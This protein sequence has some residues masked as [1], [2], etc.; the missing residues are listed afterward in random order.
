MCVCV[1]VCVVD[2][3]AF[4]KKLPGNFVINALL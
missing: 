3:G 4:T 1:C 2:S